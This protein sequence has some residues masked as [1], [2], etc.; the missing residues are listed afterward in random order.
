MESVKLSCGESRD[1]L[2]RQLTSPF[3][4]VLPGVTVASSTGTASIAVNGDGTST[5]TVT[6]ASGYFSPGNLI[7]GALIKPNTYILQQLTPATDGTWGGLGTYLLSTASTF[8]SGA[9]TGDGSGPWIYKQSP[10]SSIQANVDGTSG[11][12]TATVLID[13]SN[14]G[15]HPCGT[16]AGTITLTGTLTASDG[17]TTEAAWK[18]IRARVTA[19]TGT[20]AV[21]TCQM[22]T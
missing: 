14:D 1:M 7:A 18:Y 19:I 16:V 17:F 6:V 2:Y 10:L 5:M 3:G 9:I 4:G 12:Q 21:V 11:A 13:V 8:A 20:G 22:G 15:I